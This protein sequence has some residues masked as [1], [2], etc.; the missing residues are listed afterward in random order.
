MRIVNVVDAAQAQA[1][2]MQRFAPP[3]TDSPPRRVQAINR[4]SG[5]DDPSTVGTTPP[6]DGISLALSPESREA[7]RQAELG[8]LRDS[9]TMRDAT[10][11]KRPDAD[12]V[13]ADEKKQQDDRVRELE[14][15]DVAT[16]ARGYAHAAA[17]GSVGSAPTFTY[18]VGPDGRL[19]AVAGEVQ[20]DTSAVPGDPEATLRKAQQIER[21]AFAPG[22]PSPEDRRAAVMAMALATRAR[23]E[24]ARQQAE[25]AAARNQTQHV[26]EE[27]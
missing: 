2:V 20:I 5:P 25:D 26:S 14:Q 7:A 27:G 18:Q 11:G 6:D 13:A 24:L 15:Q 12:S 9:Q 10:D 4:Q 3:P 16:R 1:M 8:R 21:A 23:Q 17:V 19:Y 22:D